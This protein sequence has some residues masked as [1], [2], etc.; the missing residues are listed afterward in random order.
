M[1]SVSGVRWFTTF[2]DCYTQMTWIYMLK[3]KSEVLRCF[4]DFHK[5][6][7]NQFNTN[8]QII[9]TGNGTEYVN[10]EFMTYISNHG[11][12]HQ[13]TCPSTPPQN[14]V[15]ERKN[16]YLLEVARSM[17]FQMNVPKYLWS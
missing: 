11:I 5:L 14:G 10:N 4:Q 1:T 15:V 9:R 6:V 17:M 16:R 12:I 13:T 7:S 2:I 8:V 3:Q